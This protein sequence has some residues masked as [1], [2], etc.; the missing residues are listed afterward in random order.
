MIKQ[1]DSTCTSQFL[2]EFDALRVIFRLDIIV[3]IKAGMFRSSF[4]NSET[5]RVK[6]IFGL[7]ASNAFDLHSMWNLFPIPCQLSVSTFN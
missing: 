5:C 2:D 1:H 3:V 4:G 6:G 7:F